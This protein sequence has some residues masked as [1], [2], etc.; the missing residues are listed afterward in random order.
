VPALL[1]VRGGAKGPTGRW[2]APT[3]APG[4]CAEDTAL[5][6]MPDVIVRVAFRTDAR[7]CG[8]M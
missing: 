5:L 2:G 8:R 1:G 4:V 6:T 3:D 7:S